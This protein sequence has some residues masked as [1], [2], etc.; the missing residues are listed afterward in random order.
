MTE[1]NSLCCQLQTDSFGLFLILFHVCVCVLMCVLVCVC[2]CVCACVCVCVCV[3]AV[4][5]AKYSADA[6]VSGK[7]LMCTGKSLTLSCFKVARAVILL[8]PEKGAKRS[9][10]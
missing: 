10:F 6:A 5:Y 9:M 3:C 1:K 4:G 2:V 8:E 7:K